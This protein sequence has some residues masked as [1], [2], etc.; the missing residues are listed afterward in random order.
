ML[1]EK[2]PLLKK[3]DY[4]V[5]DLTYKSE[6]LNS[7]VDTVVKVSNYVDVFE[8][9]AKRNVKEWVKI[10]A[11]NKDIA[12]RIVDK[13]KDFA[14]FGWEGIIMAFKF[15]KALAVVVVG[16]L[17]IPKKGSEL[18]QYFINLVKK[19]NPQIKKWLIKLKLFERNH[20]VLNQTKLLLILNCGL[21]MSKE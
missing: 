11:R 3:F 5:E 15:V 14:K 8:A 6:M 1:L 18:R 21:K 16:M 7:N 17:I 20:K 19:Y 4:F 13:L 10:I 12:Y 9:F 2:L